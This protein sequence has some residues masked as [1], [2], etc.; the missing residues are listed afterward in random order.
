MEPLFNKENKTGYISKAKGWMQRSW[1]WP[2]QEIDRWL[3]SDDLGHL[4]RQSGLQVP[5]RAT[6]K[7]RVPS[8][9]KVPT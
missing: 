2:S 3:P 6:V 9:T 5:Q 4:T 7:G 1:N 8:H